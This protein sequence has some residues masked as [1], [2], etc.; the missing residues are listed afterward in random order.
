MTS[1]LTVLVVLLITYAA[2]RDRAQLTVDLEDE[3]TRLVR[4]LEQ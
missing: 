2:W 3:W 4:E 1:T